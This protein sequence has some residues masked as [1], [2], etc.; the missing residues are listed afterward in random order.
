[1]PRVEGA[2]HSNLAGSATGWIHTDLCSGWFD[3]LG[4]GPDT[5]LFP[6]RGRC[7]YFT[8]RTRAPDAEPR[9]YIRA[10]TLIF[11]LC[12]DGW[13]P[14]DGGETGLYS[15]AHETEHTEVSLV[16]PVNNSL[17]LFEC[18]PYSFHRF[19]A[20]PGRMRNSIILWLHSEVGVASAKWGTA[21]NR[22]GRR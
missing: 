21:V 1:L 3:E 7:D 17:L 22:L 9:E 19:V 16:P 10:A 20:N 6:P 18:S 14:G 5:L 4:V 2:L 8:G 15:S 13:L 12:N 11:F